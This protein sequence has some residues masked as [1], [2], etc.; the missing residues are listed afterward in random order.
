MRTRGTMR[1]MEAR[2]ALQG[3]SQVAVDEGLDLV[4]G[5][6]KDVI[7]EVKA[8]HEGDMSEEAW[9]EVRDRLVALVKGQ[10]RLRQ[11]H[12]EAVVKLSYAIRDM[13]KGNRLLD[14][15]VQRPR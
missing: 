3:V 13:S 15:A 12:A 8:D 7:A 9:D 1:M 10:C 2:K 11:H 14:Y 5:S 6:R 4:K